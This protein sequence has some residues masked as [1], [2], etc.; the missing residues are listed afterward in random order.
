MN[1]CDTKN[2]MMSIIYIFSFMIFHFFGG[3]PDLK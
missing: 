1:K 3:M 2:K